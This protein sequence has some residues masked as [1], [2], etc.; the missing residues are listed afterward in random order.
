MRDDT[1]LWSELHS[2]CAPVTVH[3]IGPSAESFTYRY[4]ADTVFGGPSEGYD[5]TRY[6]PTN[7]MAT[8]NEM[9]DFVERLRN[10]EASV[11]FFPI[12]YAVSPDDMGVIAPLQTFGVR[13]EN[14]GGPFVDPKIAKFRDDLYLFSNRL[15]L[16]MNQQKPASLSST[17]PFLDYGLSANGTQDLWSAGAVPLLEWERVVMRTRAQTPMGV[18]WS[19][20][21]RHC[22]GG[23]SSGGRDITIAGSSTVFPIA[24]IWAAVYQIGCPHVEITL[25]GG[26]SSRGAGRVCANRESGTPVDIGDMSREWKSSEGRQRDG[27][28][29]PFVYDCLKGD[30]ARSAIQVPVGIDGLTVATKWGGAAQECIEILGGLTMDQLRWIYSGE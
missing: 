26:G 3:I 15:I 8:I 17:R 13:E 25:E 9:A 14:W 28:D 20:V 7:A 12:R 10:S 29:A 24:Q 5:S 30:P 21:Q 23:S 27:T 2:D 18:P 11:G 16:Y 6:T 22:G 4:M 1:K 19:D